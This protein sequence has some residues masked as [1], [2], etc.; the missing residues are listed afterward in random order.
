VCVCA[1]LLMQHAQRMCRN[2]L[3]HVAW[4]SVPIFSA[5]SQKMSRFSGKKSNW[6]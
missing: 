3:S 6:T 2:I 1:A 4:P 5:L